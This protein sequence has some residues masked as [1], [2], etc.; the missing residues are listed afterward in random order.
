MISGKIRFLTAHLLICLFMTISFF[1]VTHSI[2][3][4]TFN[5]NIQ[6]PICTMLGIEYISA[7]KT[8]EAPQTTHKSQECLFCQTQMANIL[9]PN[10]HTI[11][12]SAFGEKLKFTQYQNNYYTATALKP[13][14]RGPPSFSFV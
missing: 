13:P 12:R 9:P 8:N 6:I 4:E 5:L 2:A 3:K 1:P 11:N 14:I 10:D 7:D